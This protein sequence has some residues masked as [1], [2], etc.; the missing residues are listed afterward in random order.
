MK[1]VSRDARQ[2]LW[3][4]ATALT[5]IAAVVAAVFAPIAT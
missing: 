3:A 2:R 1:P 5:A 4:A